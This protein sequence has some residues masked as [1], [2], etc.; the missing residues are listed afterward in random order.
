MARDAGTTRLTHVRG[1]A[2]KG[3]IRIWS[4]VYGAELEVEN[5][6]AVYILKYMAG[7]FN[8]LSNSETFIY[9]FFSF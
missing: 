7:T 6:H 9:L 1:T 4:K 5:L 2:L 3:K 8:L